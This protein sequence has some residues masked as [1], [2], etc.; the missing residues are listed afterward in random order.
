M[1][2]LIRGFLVL[3]IGYF[4]FLIFVQAMD[5]PIRKEWWRD[6]GEYRV[7]KCAQHFPPTCPENQR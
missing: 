2:F 5:D 6:R 4:L 7:P 3:A 1:R